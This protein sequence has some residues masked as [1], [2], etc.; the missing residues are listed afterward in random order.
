MRPES[1]ALRKE[2]ATLI[3]DTD[4][5]IQQRQTLDPGAL[6]L[7]A[8]PHLCA[9][10]KAGGGLN[11]DIDLFWDKIEQSDP[12]LPGS[13]NFR[14][15]GEIWK[16]LLLQPRAGPA[17]S[18][19]KAC[20]CCFRLRQNAC[21]RAQRGLFCHLLNGLVLSKQAPENASFSALLLCAAVINFLL[22]VSGWDK[23]APNRICVNK[24]LRWRGK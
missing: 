2:P 3:S 20:L 1:K 18:A 4:L 22:F 5:H 19:A 24:K 15:S 17:S 23:I 12:W 6:Q 16:S 14:R 7:R 10:Q 11:I 21:S 8:H 9:T 13:G